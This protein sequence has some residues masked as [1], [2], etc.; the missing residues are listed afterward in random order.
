MRSQAVRGIYLPAGGISPLH[1]L[2]YRQGEAWLCHCLEYDFIVKCHR[3]KEAALI[4]I[5][6]LVREHFHWAAASP[7][8]MPPHLRKYW[9]AS[10][11]EEERGLNLP[12]AMSPRQ[13]PS[14]ALPAE[15]VEREAGPTVW[16]SGHETVPL[17]RR[18]AWGARPAACGAVMASVLPSP[19]N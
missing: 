6:R 13:D 3:S 11:A 9:S 2:I 5:K 4:T 8:Q 14:D 19:E 17:G 12:E 16:T 1:I 7:P 15:G 18:F 10:P